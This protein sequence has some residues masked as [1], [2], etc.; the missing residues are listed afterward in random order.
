M[1]NPGVVLKVD[2]PGPK[3]P[4]SEQCAMPKISVTADVQNFTPDPKAPP[5]QYQWKVTLSFNGQGCA[6]AP[7]KIIKHDDITQTTTTNKFDIAFT[8]VRGGALTISVSVAIPGSRLTASTRDLLVTGTNPSVG[9]LA[10]VANPKL[11]FRKLM[12]VESGLKQFLSD[13]CPLFSQDGYGGAGLCQMTPANEDEIWSW[14]VNVSDG[15]DLYRTSRTQRWL[16]SK[17]CAK[18]STLRRWSR[19]TMKSAKQDFKRRMPARL[20]PFQI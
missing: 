17:A 4:I 14:K 6:N 18:V 3:F 5:L 16:M 7:Q 2:P 8:Q 1:A 19:F 10:G 12:R 15:W 9:T 20:Q 11:A 13:T